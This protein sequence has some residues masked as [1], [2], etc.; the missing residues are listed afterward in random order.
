M[1]F[2]KD[3]QRL[4]I[5]WESIKAHGCNRLTSKVDMHSHAVCK[6]GDKARFARPSNKLPKYS[7][8]IRNGDDG[9]DENRA[10]VWQRL[11][12]NIQSC[13]HVDANC[14]TE[15]QRVTPPP[16]LTQTLQTC[17]G[18]GSV[19]TGLFVE[20]VDKGDE[21]FKSEE[22]F[23][24]RFR[25]DTSDRCCFVVRAPLLNFVWTYNRVR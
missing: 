17:W 5:S 11:Y 1:R 22:N 21:L 15:H 2:Y 19:N 18:P 24:F 13:K 3:V 23:D 4:Q 16:P 6:W 9:F 12:T 14:R 25:T 8:S 10:T 20:K 7:F